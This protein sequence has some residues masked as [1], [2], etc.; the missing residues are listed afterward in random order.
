[1]CVEIKYQNG[2]RS[3]AFMSFIKRKEYE[4][5]AFQGYSTFLVYSS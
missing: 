5:C 4:G 3:A 1:M 2:D